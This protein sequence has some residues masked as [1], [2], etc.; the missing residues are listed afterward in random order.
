MQALRKIASAL[1]VP[2]IACLGTACDRAATP[3]EPSTVAGVAAVANEH[4][5]AANTIWVN[6]D[7]SSDAFVPPGTSCNDPGYPTVQSAVTAADPGDRINVCPGTYREQV[8][9]PTGKDGIRLR[10]VERWKAIIKAPAVMTSPKAIVR[11]NGAHHVG[12]RAFTITG[13]GVGG[14]RCDD[15]PLEYGVRVDD[16]GSA[17]ILGNHIT[18]IRDDPFDGCQNGVAIQVGRAVDGTSGSA[19]IFGNLIDNFQKNGITVSGDGSNGE[20]ANNR[21]FGIGP[22]LII[23]QN[24][25]QVSSGATARVR[26][27]VVANAIYT[28][29]TFVSTG[30]LLF[31]SGKVVTDD[32]TATSNDVGIFLFEAGAGSTT[33][34]NRARGSTF[35]GIAIDMF[36]VTTLAASHVGGSQVAHNKSDHNGGPGIGLYDGVR[37]NKLDDN[38]VEDNVDSGILLD[39]ASNTVVS[40]N[41]VNDNGTR[42]GDITDGIR[43]NAGSGNTIR[44]N[45]LKNNVKHDC[46]EGSTGNKWTDNHAETSFPQGLC[47]DKDRDE[48]KG[49]VR[50]ES[51]LQLQSAITASA[52]RRATVSPDQ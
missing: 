20:I 52:V 26:N 38:D 40:G 5:G 47:G 19:T 3:T 2:M 51:I 36:T 21:V 16:G 9:I 50:T 46:H 14:G 41:G 44:D 45:R 8:I 6:D 29:E 13:P 18:Q 27:N 22:T 48:K 34:D 10:S 24:G 43:I 30:I 7:P 39:D 12:I 23:A 37:G 11:V 28:P 42:N 25:I 49:N 1:I 32:N 33:T 31:Q 35:D 17:D 4:D 15:P